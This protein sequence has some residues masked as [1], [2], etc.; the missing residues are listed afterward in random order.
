MRTLL[1]LCMVSGLVL[2]A[3]IKQTREQ[4]KAEVAGLWKT[5]NDPKDVVAAT[6]AF[7]A[8]LDHPYTVEFLEQELV[9]VKCTKA[10][11]EKWLE[12]LNTG[13][14]ETQKKAIARLNFFHPTMYLTAEEIADKLTTNQGAGWITSIAFAQDFQFPPRS[15]QTLQRVRYT[16]NNGPNSLELTTEENVANQ[17]SKSTRNLDLL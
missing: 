1:V 4:V 14:E 11:I 9:A 12:D 16:G 17:F 3:P 13:D 10:E 15:P 8:L 2:A 5:A 7:F 6:R